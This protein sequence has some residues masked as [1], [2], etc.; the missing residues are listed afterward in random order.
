VAPVEVHSAY[1]YLP[2]QFLQT[3][4]NR[5]D[6]EYGGPVENRARFLLEVRMDGEG[7]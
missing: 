3:G 2:D 7:E 1:G 5:R 6:D 4:T